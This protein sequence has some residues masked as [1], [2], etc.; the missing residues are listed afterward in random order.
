MP[1][2]DQ[3]FDL[4]F[5]RFVAE[6]LDDPVAVM[7]ETRRVLKPGGTLLF[8]TPNRWYYSMIGAAVTPHWFHER[9]LP[10]AGFKRAREDIFPT[11]YRCNSRRQINKAL[12]AAGL[13]GS[14]RF[15]STPPNYLGF[16]PWAFLVGV[17]YERTIERIFPALRS[18]IIV[19]ARPIA[20]GSSPRP[21]GL[22]PP[23]SSA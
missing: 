4:V 17:A 1:W 23:R 21:V 20:T 9:Y 19:E 18:K 6:H 12:E 2:P 10:L 13:R 16:H 14:I 22:R 5:H 15:L 11:L 3:T 7:R 8:E